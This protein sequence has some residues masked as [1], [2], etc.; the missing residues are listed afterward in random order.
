MRM[1]LPPLMP[2]TKKLMIANV[3][4]FFVSWILALALPEVKQ[5]LYGVLALDPRQWAAWFP[6]LPVWQLVTSGFL[7]STELITHVLWNMVQ[8]YFFGTMLEAA[9]GSRRFLVT[10]ALCLVAGSVLHIFVELATGTPQPAV[11]A[12]GA[13]LGIVVAMAT[14][15]PRAQVF[16]F[17]IPVLLW[18]LAA[19]IVG[20]DFMNAV[21][22][23]VR[24]GS[25][26]VA[27]WVH[28][29]GALFGFLCVR[30]GWIQTDWISRYQAKRAVSEEQT[31]RED[32]LRMDRLLEKIS[33]NGMSS[34]SKAEKTFLK[35]V[36]SRK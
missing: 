16:V 8:L 14:L 7:H 30:L 22:E 11:G 24:G 6:L 4:V 17:F 34:L 21:S 31:R 33:R 19:V 20:L 32:E 15:R 29:G 27:H 10:Y 23:L 1:A 25:G 13:V 28:L 2:V 26:G 35:R 5:A 9:I 12:S 3:A 18:I 36:S